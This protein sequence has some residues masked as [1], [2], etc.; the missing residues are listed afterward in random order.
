MAKHRYLRNLHANLR[1]RWNGEPVTDGWPRAD[2]PEKAVLDEPLEVCYH[3][4]LMMEE[5]R[6]TVFRVAFTSGNTPVYP[7]G[8][9]PSRL[10]RSSST[11]LASRFRSLWGNCDGSRADACHP[12]TLSVRRDAIKYD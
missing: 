8:G 1:H 9:S 4:S 6:P 10:S 12:E 11:L 3:A 2:L 7:R 5:G